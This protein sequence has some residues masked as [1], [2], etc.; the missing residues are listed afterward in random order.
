M[1]FTL[2]VTKYSALLED[3]FEFG[4]FSETEREIILTFGKKLVSEDLKE[5]DVIEWFNYNGKKV[6]SWYL[7]IFTRWEISYRS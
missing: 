5:E 6:S 4:S 7:Y 1:I 2:L 3:I